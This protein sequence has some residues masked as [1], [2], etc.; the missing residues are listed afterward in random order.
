MNVARGYL[1]MEELGILLSF[2]VE[3]LKHVL[4][5]VGTIDREGEG[6]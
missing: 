1:D 6:L 5:V 4:G 3:Q 2:P